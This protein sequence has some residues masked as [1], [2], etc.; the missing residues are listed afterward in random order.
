MKKPKNDNPKVVLVSST[1]N[2]KQKGQSI[3]LWLFLYLV[4][5]DP[6]PFSPR[7]VSSSESTISITELCVPR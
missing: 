1:N 2:V 5:E 4:P 3:T 6:Q 7:S